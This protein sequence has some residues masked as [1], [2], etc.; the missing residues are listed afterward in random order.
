MYYKVSID[1]ICTDSF[2][3]LT[4]EKIQ[5]GAHASVHIK[6]VILLFMYYTHLLHS[7]TTPQVKTST[8]PV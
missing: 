1:F 5:I 6:T 4:C 3:Q 7:S 8:R 2:W